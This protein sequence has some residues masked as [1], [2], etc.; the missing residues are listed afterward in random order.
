M[1]RCSAELGIILERLPKDRHKQR[2][3]R[4]KDLNEEVAKA[5]IIDA[6]DDLVAAFTDVP[7]AVDYLE[8]GRPQTSFATSACF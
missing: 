6:M 8:F 3:V 7:A 1:R 5:A 4:L 2:R